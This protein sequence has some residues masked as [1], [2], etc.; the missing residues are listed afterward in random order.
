MQDRGRQLLAVIYAFEISEG[1]GRRLVTEEEV[2]A[3][4]LFMVQP[5]LEAVPKRS[6]VDSGPGILVYNNFQDARYAAQTIAKVAMRVAMR[7]VVAGAEPG[8]DG[9]WAT[10]SGARYSGVPG[11]VAEVV[12]A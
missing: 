1:A 10:A 8:A 7:E 6:L 11:G 3:S 2:P 12:K 5:Q 9:V 4:T